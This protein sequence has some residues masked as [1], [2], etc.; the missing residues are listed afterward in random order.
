MT[1]IKGRDFEVN[2]IDNLY[3]TMFDPELTRHFDVG[4]EILCYRDA[5]D[6]IELIR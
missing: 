5:I 4:R 3:L 6:C 2:A 1:C